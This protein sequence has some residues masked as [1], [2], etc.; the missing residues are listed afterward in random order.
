MYRDNA[1]RMRKLFEQVL[2]SYDLQQ[3]ALDDA[4]KE[5]ST[6]STEMTST[7]GRVTATVN[8]AGVTTAI[9]LADNA[10]R[11]ATPDELSRSILEAVHSAV[12]TAKQRTDQIIAP[13]TSAEL[14]PDLD[15]VLPDAAEIRELRESIVDRFDRALRLPEPDDRPN[16]K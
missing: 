13:L 1:H 3:A 8:A 2:D 4:L 10:F 16:T 6:A 5:L 15:D 14:T 11:G 9:E 12:H 7:D